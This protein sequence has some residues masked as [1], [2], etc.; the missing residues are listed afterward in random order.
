MYFSSPYPS[1]LRPLP[2]T[3]LFSSCCRV[4][5]LSTSSRA[6]S[7][8]CVFYLGL[9]FLYNRESSGLLICACWVFSAVTSIIFNVMWNLKCA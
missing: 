8:F 7:I 2:H 1:T 3:Y 6:I 9:A 4:S 5:G